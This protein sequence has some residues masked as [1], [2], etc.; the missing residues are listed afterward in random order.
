MSNERDERYDPVSYWTTLHHR[1]ELSTVGQSGLPANTNRWLYA[2]LARSL[3][4][5]VDRHRLNPIEVYEIG[6]G[7]GYWVDW[8]S[9]RGAEVYGSDL[10][11]EAVDGLRTRF[12]EFFTV[13]DISAETPP[14]TAPLVVVMNVLLHITDDEAFA[15]SLAHVASSVEAGGHLLMVEPIQTSGRFHR[16]YRSGTSSV[17]RSQ[18]A[19]VH[20]LADAGLEL[21]ALEP[22]SGVASDPIEAG[23]PWLLL[24]ENF[25]WRALKAPAKIGFGDVSGRLI[26]ALDPLALRL[27]ARYSSKFLLMRRP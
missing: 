8:W 27:G 12:G 13:L 2:A 11:P 25:A 16:A 4:K 1:R 19:Y 7:T 6:A 21:V 26:Y 10:V 18:E 9:R 22:A 15:A 20:P 3:G 14:R 5:F 23:S 24:L 17:A